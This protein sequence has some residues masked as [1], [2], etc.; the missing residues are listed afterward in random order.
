MLTVSKSFLRRELLIYTINQSLIYSELQVEQ[1]KCWFSSCCKP[2]QSLKGH[3]LIKVLKDG[4]DSYTLF[5]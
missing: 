3:T 4:F 5:H 1:T 2:G